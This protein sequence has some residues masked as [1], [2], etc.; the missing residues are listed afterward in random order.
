MTMDVS[1]GEKIKWLREDR[2]LSRSQLGTAVLPRSAALPSRSTTI[3]TA[4]LTVRLRCAIFMTVLSLISR[5]NAD[6]T[7][8]SFSTLRLTVAS[9][10]KVIGASLK[11][12]AIEMR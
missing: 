2:N 12:H 7:A 11:K 4:E 5:D 8:I 6:R 3:I 1:F 10:S 9:S